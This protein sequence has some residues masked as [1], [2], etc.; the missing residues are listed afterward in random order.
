MHR[1]RPLAAA[2]ALMLTLPACG[3]MAP[4]LAPSSAPADPSASDQA[5]GGTPAIH[6]PALTASAMASLM[7]PNR[8]DAHLQAFQAIADRSGGNRATGSA[9]Y[10]RSM[11]YVTEQLTDAGYAVERLAFEAD[12]TSGTNLVADREGTAEGVLVVGAHLDSV[13]AGPGMN[14]NASGV[15]ALLMLAQAMSQ[16]A[17]PAMTV[18]F[19]FW[20]A[21]EGGPIGSR[22]YL[23]SLDP[24]SLARIRAYLNV[25]MVGSPNGVAFIYDE[26]GAAPG[27]DA[28][29]NVVS[30]YFRQRG[31][32]WEPIDL[33][34]D[35]DH[36]PF[37]DAGIPTGGMF[38]G[39]IEP[40][41]A[42]QAARY[43]SI[44]GEPADPCS[45]LACDTIDNVDLARMALIIEAL[46]AA[47]VNLAASASS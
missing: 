5:D 12:G 17:P 38:A 10:E 21:E 29:T 35:S 7:D 3:T 16:L 28:I 40:V 34:G 42:E 32:P 46:G 23:E 24:A 27:S 2:L 37:I 41:T 44:A 47:I 14:D 33:A 39:G 13:A 4:S 18:R 11:D 9:G 6:A 31:R 45:H 22:E 1:S 8:M 43:G 19:A 20:D 26:P 15:V 36:G 30:R 25:D